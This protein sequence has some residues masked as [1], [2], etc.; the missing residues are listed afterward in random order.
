MDAW[1]DEIAAAL[2]VDPLAPEDTEE[3]LGLA[4]DVAHGVERKVTP[5]AAFLL[6]AGVQRRISEGA[7]RPDALAAAVADLRAHVPVGG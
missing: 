5:L 6:G 2:G 3:L 1:L 7:P 4:R